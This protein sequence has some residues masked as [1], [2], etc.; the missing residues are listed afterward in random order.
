M[1]PVRKIDILS[2]GYQQ[3]IVLL[4]LHS[5]KKHRAELRAGIHR[6]V[7]TTHLFVQKYFRAFLVEGP[8]F[9]QNWLFSELCC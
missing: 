2:L 3:T 7:V 5:L 6:P 9:F 1:Q 4:F 8:V